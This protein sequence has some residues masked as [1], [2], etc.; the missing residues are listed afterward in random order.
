M[1][2]CLCPLLIQ[3]YN[4]NM[5]CVDKFDQNKKNVSNRQEK[6]KM[7]ASNFLFFL[8]YFN[9]NARIIYNEI[10]QENMNMNEFRRQVSKELVANMLI[11]KRWSSSDSPVMPKYLKKGSLYVPK[12][13]CLEQSA[14][15]PQRS[16]RRRCNHCS[17]KEKEVR[18]DWICSVC[19]VPL[20]LG[21]VKNC[22]AKHH[23]S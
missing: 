22:F 20:C 8:W 11:K 4:A 5:N 6:P 15:Q 14:H 2:L 3:G 16:T 18:T 9:I 19:E 17:L 7:V 12:E 13:V 1:E 23:K 10:T 21:K